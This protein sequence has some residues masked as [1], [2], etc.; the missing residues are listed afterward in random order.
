VL[1]FTLEDESGI[2]EVV[3][4]PGGGRPG[5]VSAGE[6]LRVEG[7]VAAHLG[8]PAVQAERVTVTGLNPLEEGS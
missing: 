8:A 4:R 3:S 7:R 1:F 5:R 6:V 2:V